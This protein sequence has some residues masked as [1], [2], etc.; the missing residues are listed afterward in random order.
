[1]SMNLL[2]LS[3]VL[4]F[5]SFDFQT[6]TANQ[7]QPS[8]G[9]EDKPQ[10]EVLAVVDGV[11]INKQ[12]LSVDTRTK[13]NLAHDTV[14]ETRTRELDL[15]I[16][17]LLLSNE[18]TRRGVTTTKLLNQE[19][20]AKI[21]PPTEA[22]AQAFY[23]RNKARIAQDFKA[24]KDNLLEYL[25]NER[26]RARAQE[27]ANNLRSAG[28]V[29]VLVQ[30]VT[31]P[32]T[33]AELQRV[34]ATVNGKKITSADIEENLKA[35]IFQVQQQVYAYRKAEL[36]MKINDMLLEREAKKRGIPA[37]TLIDTEV[38]SKLTIATEAQAEKF[39]NENKERINGEFARVKGQIIQY[40]QSQEEQKLQLAFAERLRNSIPLQVFLT[41]PESPFFQIAID[42]QPTKGNPNAAVTVVEFT[43]F[44][45]PTCAKQHAVLEKLVAEFGSQAKFVVRDFPLTRHPH[46]AKAAEAAEIAREQGKYWEYIPILYRN[47]GALQIEE[48]RDYAVSIG[49]D[50]EEF[51]TALNSGKMAAHVERDLMDGSKLGVDGTPTFFVNGRRV[52][53]ISYEGLKAAIQAALKKPN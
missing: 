41:A 7:A 20:T 26:E 8:C 15:Q 2:L 38:T 44:E 51:A 43:D 4:A 1:M 10:L 21:T 52:T 18:A 45:C 39:Y 34:F 33:P 30:N 27:F 46:A 25:K 11:K 14:I 28:N 24:V 19:V 35:V 29:Q 13:I 9:C 23:E 12:D 37:R 50:R 40:L 22:E 32:A 48:L 16:N 36:D 6:P 31:P 3:L 53:D 49:L 17:S 5:S 47:Q 42:D